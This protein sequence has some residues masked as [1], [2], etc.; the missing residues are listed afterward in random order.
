[1]GYIGHDEY[2]WVLKETD[3]SVITENDGFDLDKYPDLILKTGEMS[4]Y[5]DVP[6][7]FKLLYLFSI[8]IKQSMY[9]FILTQFR[10]AIILVTIEFIGS[11]YTWGTGI[12][13]ITTP[14]YLL[15]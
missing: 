7:I 6:S 10:K 13:I 4:K 9:C 8:N 5:E 14:L 1:M 2:A 11:F 12:S 3:F 15:L